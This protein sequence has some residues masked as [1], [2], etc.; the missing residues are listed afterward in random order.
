MRFMMIVK[1][2][3][4]SEAG[5]P[6]DPRLMAATHESAKELV[7]AGVMVFTGALAPTRA[8]VRIQVGDGQLTQIDGPFAEATELVGGFAIFEV[9]SKEEA[10]QYGRRYMAMHQEVMGPTYHGQLEIRQILGPEDFAPRP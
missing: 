6:P 3:T 9:A 8:G 5:R 2:T 1:C 10:I 7:Q 4:D